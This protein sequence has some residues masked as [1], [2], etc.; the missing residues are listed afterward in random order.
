M[1]PAKSVAGLALVA[2]GAVNDS[3]LALDA[4]NES[5]TAA[6]SGLRDPAWVLGAV[7]GAAA[8]AREHVRRCCSSENGLGEL[9]AESVRAAVFEGAGPSEAALPPPFPW[10][11]SRQSYAARLPWSRRALPR[12]RRH[13]TRLRRVANES[14]GASGVPNESFATSGPRVRA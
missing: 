12:R 1:A 4:R 14:W 7:V 13:R 2:F 10:V 5:F 11:G 3:F 8:P 6:S 9:S